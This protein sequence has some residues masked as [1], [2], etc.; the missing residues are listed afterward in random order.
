M[1]QNCLRNSSVGKFN[2]LSRSSYGRVLYTWTN[3]VARLWTPSIKFTCF[4]N[5]GDQT[6]CAYSRWGRTNVQYNVYKIFGVRFSKPRLIMPSM[7]LALFTCLAMCSSNDNSASIRIPRSFSE[8]TC[9]SWL[10]PREYG[11]ACFIFSSLPSVNTW[12]LPGWKE[13]NQSFDHLPRQFDPFGTDFY[14][15]WSIFYRLAVR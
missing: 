7:E 3:L 13:S 1:S 12:H 14:Q 4:R 8:N 15:P 9:S 2:L 10:P 11:C 6:D 5:F